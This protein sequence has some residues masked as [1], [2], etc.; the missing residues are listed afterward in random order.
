MNISIKSQCVFSRRQ[1]FKCI[2]QLIESIFSNY[3]GKNCHV[4][5][6]PTV[7]PLVVYKLENKFSDQQFWFSAEGKWSNNNPKLLLKEPENC[8]A[9]HFLSASSINSALSKLDSL[10]LHLWEK[11]LMTCHQHLARGDLTKCHKHMNSLPS[12]NIFFLSDWP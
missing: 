11:N 3:V 9:R 4:I 8:T 7:L 10:L 6:S 2:K 1:T 12:N 5:V